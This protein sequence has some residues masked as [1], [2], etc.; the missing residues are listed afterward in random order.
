M[1]VMKFGGT[2]VEGS[3]AIERAADIVRRRL[4][5][6]PVVVVS[7]LAGITDSMLVMFTRCSFRPTVASLRLTWTNPAAAR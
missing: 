5:P 2:S 7:A 4:E 3:A 1:I 6:R